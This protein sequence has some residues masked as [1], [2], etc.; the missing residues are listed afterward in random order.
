MVQPCRHASPRLPALCLL[1]QPEQSLLNHFLR[2]GRRE[3]RSRE[4]EETRRFP[5][6][7]HDKGGL[8]PRRDGCHQLF[9][10]ADRILFRRHARLRQADAPKIASWATL[11]AKCGRET[12]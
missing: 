1:P 12:A 11:P 6:N 5:P 9:V 10:A 4:T 2:L 7:E 8:I 3:E